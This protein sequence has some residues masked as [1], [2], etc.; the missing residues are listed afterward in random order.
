M[1]TVQFAQLG[2]TAK[3]PKLITAFVAVTVT[4]IVLAEA[5]GPQVTRQAPTINANLPIMPDL[6]KKVAIGGNLLRRL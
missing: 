1:V 2:S 4:A 6:Y 5:T 3:E